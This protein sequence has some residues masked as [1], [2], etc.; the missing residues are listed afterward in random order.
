[1]KE[2]L[3]TKVVHVHFIHGRKNYYFGS[4]S[5]IF[6]KFSENQ[7]GVSEDYLRH[8]LFRDNMTYLNNKVMIV[9]SRIIRKS[10]K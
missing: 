9:R 1:M 2:V 7:I 8:Y 5:A 6:S 3:G 4:I 10:N